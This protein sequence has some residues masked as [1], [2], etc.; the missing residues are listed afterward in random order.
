MNQRVE[1]ISSFQ[2]AMNQIQKQKYEPQF[3]PK[4]SPLYL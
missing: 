4:K 3:D 1:P 2:K